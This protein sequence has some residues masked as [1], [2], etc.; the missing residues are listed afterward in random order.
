MQ[1]KKKK[2][3]SKPYTVVACQYATSG[4]MRWVLRILIPITLAW[5]YSFMTILL[6][7]VSRFRSYLKLPKNKTENQPKPSSI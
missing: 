6:H 2:I 1:K 7:R 5:V 4:T 3:Q